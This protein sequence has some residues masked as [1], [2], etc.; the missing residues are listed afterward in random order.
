MFSTSFL[1]EISQEIITNRLE[2]KLRNENYFERFQRITDCRPYP[3]MHFTEAEKSCHKNEL[4][5][6]F[7]G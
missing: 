6:Y 3:K 7:A 4:M 1:W 5:Q 2:V